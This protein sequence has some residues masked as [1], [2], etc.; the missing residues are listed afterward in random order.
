MVPAD[1]AVMTMKKAVILDGLGSILDANP[2]EVFGKSTAHNPSVTN[3]MIFTVCAA[4]AVKA[5]GIPILNAIATV[6]IG[7]KVPVW[8]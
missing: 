4:A 1:G 7:I 5:M 2:I 6:A 8:Q 3:G